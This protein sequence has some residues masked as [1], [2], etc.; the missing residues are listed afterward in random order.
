MINL[1]L[2]DLDGTLCDCT[3]LHYVALND[4]LQDICGFVI[5]RQEHLI[6]FNGLPTK[7]KLKILLSEQ[8]IS[9][10]EQDKIWNDKQRYTK[11]AIEKI[12]YLEQEKIKI[13]QYLKSRNIKIGCVTN[14][15]E[16]TA[17]LI[18]TVTGQIEYIDLL[19]TNDKVTK[20]KPDPEGFFKS[21]RY[22]N[23]TPSKTLIVEDSLVGLQAAQMTGADVWKINNSAELTL[24]NILEKIHND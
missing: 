23:T 5:D 16:E 1:V 15:I 18:L 24:E 8:R 11:I 22:F 20:P 12:L 4:A 2:F 13:H 7:E 14:S 9:N 19:I 17:K 10:I 21:I 3:E 6:K